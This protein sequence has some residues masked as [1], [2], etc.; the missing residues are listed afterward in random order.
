[1][2]QRMQAM[3]IN[4]SSPFFAAQLGKLQRQQSANQAGGYN[5]L[6]LQAS[7]LRQQALG[8]AGSYRPLQTGQTQTQQQSGLGTWLP[9]LIG[10]G[11]GIAGGAMGGGAGLAMG[12]MFKG[13]SSSALNNSIAGNNAFIGGMNT[14]MD[15]PQWQGQ[16]GVG[17]Q[18]F[19]PFLPGGGA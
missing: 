10:A 6:L 18:T 11:L 14:G 19:N 3:G 17:G 1:M 12:S 7:Q 5:N 16:G 8:Q 9:Q 15:L 4:Q 13:G 2:L